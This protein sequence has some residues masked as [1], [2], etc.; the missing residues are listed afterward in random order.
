ML[1]SQAIIDG[2]N[3]RPKDRIEFSYHG[4]IRHGTIEEIR[5]CNN[6][7]IN[8]LCNTKDGFRQFRTLD[9][10]NVRVKTFWGYVRKLIN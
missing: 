6:G 8:L 7:R 3:I 1:I 4:V 5:E 9:M 10:T 2:Q